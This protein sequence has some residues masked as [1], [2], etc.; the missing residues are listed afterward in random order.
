MDISFWIPDSFES[1]DF[2]DLVRSVGGDLVEHVE[3]FDVFQNPKTQK[4]SHTYRITYRHM[5]KTLSK[6]EVNEIHKKI[7]TECIEQF[8]VQI[9]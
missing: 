2:F 7:E 1:N 8:G 9:R 3:N 6:E 4:T 5:E